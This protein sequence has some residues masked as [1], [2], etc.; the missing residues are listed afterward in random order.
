[1]SQARP[2]VHGCQPRQGYFHS[3]HGSRYRITTPEKWLVQCH[4]HLRSYVCAAKACKGERAYIHI[5][6]FD[7]SY[8]GGCAGEGIYNT[9]LASKR[10]VGKRQNLHL[11]GKT[12]CWLANHCRGSNLKIHQ[13]P[14]SAQ[15]NPPISSRKLH[16]C[17][18]SADSRSIHR[19]WFLEDVTAAA[20][21]LSNCFKLLVMMLT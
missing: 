16:M 14:R 1:M 15:A 8:T 11:S 13:Q 18:L 6:R 17:T 20:S 21:N 10:G 2:A 3:C 7:L 4:M 9:D 12:G 5:P 19:S